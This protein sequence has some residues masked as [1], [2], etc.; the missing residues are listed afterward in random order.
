MP[1]LIQN[2]TVSLADNYNV[3]IGRIN[4]LTFEMVSLECNHI[5]CGTFEGFLIDYSNVSSVE[6]LQNTTT[7]YGLKDNTNKTFIEI[8]ISY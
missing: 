1:K 2:I 6:L 7:Y 4:K 5:K 3:N 8:E